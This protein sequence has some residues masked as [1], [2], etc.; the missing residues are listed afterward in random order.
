MPPAS[1]PS[2]TDFMEQIGAKYPLWGIFLFIGFSTLKQHGRDVLRWFANRQPD[3]PQPTYS[4][5]G[6]GGAMLT[7]T[8]IVCRAIHDGDERII[9]ALGNGHDRIIEAIE[10]SGCRWQPCDC[11][12]QKELS[13]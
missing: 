2:I 7:Q 9:A 13:K 3:P 5:N 4:S 1:M 11:C 8:D 6:N 12:K 10:N